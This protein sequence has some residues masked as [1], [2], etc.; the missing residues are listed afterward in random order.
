MEL[1]G[2][3][4]IERS[5]GP[6]VPTRLAKAEQIGFVKICW[7]E[8]YAS[9]YK[10]LS[11]VDGKKWDTLREVTNG[12]GGVEDVTVNGVK[13]QYL[14]IDG[15]RGAKGISAYSIREIEVYERPPS[16]QPATLPQHP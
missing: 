15:S 1:P 10:L 14:K 7:G 12:H 5:G 13:S 2:L 16:T 6:V 11:S 4:E 9:D 3:D 8:T